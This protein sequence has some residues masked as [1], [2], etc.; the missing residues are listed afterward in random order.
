MYTDI[1]G[2]ILAGGKSSRM[3]VN[4]SFLKLGNQ[5]IIERIID[6][7]KSI[8]SELIIITNTPDDY[9]HLNLSLYEDVYRWKGPLAGIHSALLHSSTEKIFVLSCD[10]PLM[11]KEMIEYIIEYESDKPIKYCEAAGYHQPLVG[12]YSRA[13][14]N[15]VEKFISSTEIS[16][17][18]FH[19][20]LKNIDAEIIHPKGL[21]FYKD[22]LF[23]NV[24]R[25]EDYEKIISLY[26]MISDDN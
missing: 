14:L 12:L 7:M 26:G 25:P 20:F 11:S 21:S 1:T 22:E 15:D 2:V 16:D 18:S 6:L 4:K 24:N 23:F 13:I 5:T 3:G 10:V 19:Y 17:K 9:K 8:F